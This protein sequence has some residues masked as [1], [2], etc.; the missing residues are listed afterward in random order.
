MSRLSN[1]LF[2]TGFTVLALGAIPASAQDTSQDRRAGVDVGALCRLRNAGEERDRDSGRDVEKVRG[3]KVAGRS[4]DVFLRDTQSN[5]AITV[6]LMNAFIQTDKVDIIIGPD[7]SNAA[8]A[9]VPPWK[10]LEDRPIWFMPGGSSDVIEKEVGP[11]PYFFHTYAWSYYYHENNVNAL[12]ALGSKKKVAL[13][14]SDGA[15]GRAHIEDA[16]AYLKEAGFEIVAD[17]LVR[18]GSADYNPTL[19]KIRARRPDIL[20]VLVQTND[21]IQLTKQIHAARLN[22]PYLV[23]TAQDSATRVAGSDRRVTGLLDGRHHVGARTELPCR[24]ER[25]AA[26][27]GRC[28]LGED[29]VREVQDIAGLP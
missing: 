11:D 21:A 6:S 1:S 14:Y 17:E 19:A 12:K 24:Q 7:G 3:D 15:Y 22:V 13:L 23:G 28:R 8:A 25:A 10:K 27:P 2:F 18:E 26:F 5:N 9:A 20:Y 4:I 29:V 16:R